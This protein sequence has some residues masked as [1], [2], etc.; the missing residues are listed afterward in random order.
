[1]VQLCQTVHHDVPEGKSP[2]HNVEDI[3]IL[4]QYQN[5]VEELELVS[6]HFVIAVCQ[7]HDNVVKVFRQHTFFCL[8]WCHVK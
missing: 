2:K 6:F 7:L 1:V 3:Q 4:H 8:Y 5:D